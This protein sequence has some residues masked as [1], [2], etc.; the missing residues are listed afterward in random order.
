MQ[1]GPVWV[2]PLIA[3]IHINLVASDLTASVPSPTGILSP[4]SLESESVVSC[5]LGDGDL[6]DLIICLHILKHVM[7]TC[8]IILQKIK[9]NMQRSLDT[10]NALGRNKQI[11]PPASTNSNQDSLRIVNFFQDCNIYKKGTVTFFVLEAS[12]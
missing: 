1:K 3:Y 10:L 9:S 2:R 11:P 6:L 5:D 8:H 7:K 12:P 4:Q